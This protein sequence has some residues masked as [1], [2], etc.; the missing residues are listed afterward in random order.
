MSSGSGPFRG[1]PFMSHDGRHA[2]VVNNGDETISIIDLASNKVAATLEGGPEMLGVN[3]AAGKAFAISAPGFVYVYD[4]GSL[5]SAGRIKIRDQRPDR[6]GDDRHAGNEALSGRVNEPPGCDYRCRNRGAR[7]GGKCRAVSMGHAHPGQPGQL[8]PLNCAGRPPAG[9]TGWR[10]ALFSSPTAAVPRM[11][12]ACATA[13]A[14][15]LT[16]TVRPR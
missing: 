5:K 11:R 13:R 10:S 1:V 9:R 3:F 14:S 16:L 7:N 6:D 2:V 12:R 8:L 4:M 15:R